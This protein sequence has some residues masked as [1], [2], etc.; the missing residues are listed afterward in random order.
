MEKNK[1][2]FLSFI[3]IL[4]SMFTVNTAAASSLPDFVELV[5]KAQPSVVSIATTIK[6]PRRNLFSRS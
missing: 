6:V 1:Q 2:L 5:E 4:T 3:V